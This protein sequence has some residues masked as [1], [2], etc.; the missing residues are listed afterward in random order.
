MTG[1]DLQGIIHGNCADAFSVL[2]PHKLEDG[3]WEV[4]AFLPR[5]AAAWLRVSGDEEPF[6]KVHE[7]GLFTVR[8]AEDGKSVDLEVPLVKERVYQFTLK[9]IVGADGAAM[10]NANAYYTLNR[11]RAD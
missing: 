2:G 6:R 9:N 8:V 4:T 7:A 11:L 3:S 5:A 10:T 1:Q